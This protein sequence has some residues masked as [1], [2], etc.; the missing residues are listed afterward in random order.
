MLYIVHKLK[1]N[2]YLCLAKNDMHD[3]I[4]NHWQSLFNVKSCDLITI[5][6]G[7]KLILPSTL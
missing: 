2:K 7:V 6:T 5:I 1:A 3:K 4:V